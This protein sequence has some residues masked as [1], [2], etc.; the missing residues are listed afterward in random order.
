[1]IFF[2]EIIDECLE[3]NIDILYSFLYLLEECDV[4]DMLIY[5]K[6]VWFE[7]YRKFSYILVVKWS[8]E[9]KIELFWLVDIE[10]ISYVFMF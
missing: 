1:M 2:I 4:G 6:I 10:F 8:D 9:G 7:Y 3:I 5:F